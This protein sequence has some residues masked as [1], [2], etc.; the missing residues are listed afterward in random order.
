MDA[1]ADGDGD[2]FLTAVT[3][4]TAVP[5]PRDATQSSQAWAISSQPSWAM[6]Q[7]VRPGNERKSV[8]TGEA[9]CARDIRRTMAGVGPSRRP[10]IH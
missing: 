2:A 10:A 4:R 9:Q 6:S 5:S 1:L 3:G 8:R 7:E